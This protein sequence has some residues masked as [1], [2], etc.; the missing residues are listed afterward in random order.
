M[1]PPEEREQVHLFHTLRFCLSNILLYFADYFKSVDIIFNLNNWVCK[2]LEIFHSC[3]FILLPPRKQL[4]ILYIEVIWLNIAI[5]FSLY[6]WIQLSQKYVSFSHILLPLRNNCLFYIPRSD[7][8]EQIL[9]N[10]LIHILFI[11][12]F[13]HFLS[14][15]FYCF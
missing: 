10:I 3:I 14:T 7:W 2:S 15:E 4:S 11:F 6:H 5:I 13:S 12:I 9:L 8:I 1:K